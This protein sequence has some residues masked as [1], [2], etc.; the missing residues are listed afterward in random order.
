[1]MS[2]KAKILVVDDEPSQRKM[3]KANLSL[4]G[5]QVFEADDG[6]SAIHRVSEEFFDLILMDNRMSSMDGIDALKEIKNISPGIPVIII[7]AYASVETAVEALQAG[8]HDYLTKPLDIEELKIK[9][10]QSLEFWRLKEENI[11]QKR[12]IENL[13][14]ASRIVGRSLKMKEVLETV[15]MVAPTEATVLVLGESGTGKELIANALH[16]GSART[17]KRFIKVNCAALPETLLESELFGHEKGA[18][19]GAVGR[20]PGRFELADGGTIFLDEIG[21]MT[22]ATQ[23]KLLRV[24]QER[25]IEPLGSTRTVKVDIRI[26]TASNRILREE[27]RRGNFREDLFYRLNVVPITIPPLRE[28]REDIPLLIEHFLNIYNEKNGRHL[29]G[30]HPRALDA[31]MRYSWPGNIRELENVVERAV[32][33]SK[34][35]YVPF[36]DLPEA[37]RGASGDQLSEQAREGIRPGMTIREMEKELIMKTLEDNDGNRTRAARVLGITR[38]TLQHKLKEYDLE[39]HS[40]DASPD[41]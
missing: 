40:T 39:T 32:I 7:T 28:R 4:E 30:F 41:A 33:L 10:Q 19:T 34:D 8:A 25:E 18:F 38:R 37:I 22:L 6:T 11:L 27:V 13:F 16:Q 5:Y 23:A 26:V 9:V 21:E 14:D 3:L 31:I 17:D 29:L 12:R 36:S 2:P 35:D 15:A 24:L 20:R 1:M